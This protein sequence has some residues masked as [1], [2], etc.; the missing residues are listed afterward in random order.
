MNDFVVADPKRCIGCRTCEVACVLAH[1]GENALEHLTADMF[2]PRLQVIRTAK[3]S[4]PVQCR[5]CEDAPCARA[6]T[7]DAIRQSGSSVQVVAGKCVGCKACLVACPYGA[8]DL[9]AADAAGGKTEVAAYKCDLCVNH[10]SG[11]ACVRVCPT[12]ALQKF[13][14]SLLAGRLRNKR[15]RAALGSE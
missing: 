9:I 6:C 14:G 8:I 3:V 12:K 11:P 13:E 5:Q 10:A 15:R 4:M 2:Y 1:G 7:V